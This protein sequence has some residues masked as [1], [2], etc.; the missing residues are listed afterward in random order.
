VRDADVDEVI[1]GRPTRS[2]D[3]GVNRSEIDSPEDGLQG[4]DP[5]T[6]LHM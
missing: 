5:F 2:R 6:L 4:S 1:D 3:G